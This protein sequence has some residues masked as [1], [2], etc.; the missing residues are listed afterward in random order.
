MTITLIATVLNEGDNIQR[1]MDTIQQQ[2]LQPD[3]IVIV[4]GG[5]RDQT[6]D[7]LRRYESVLPL[8]IFIEP[9]ANISRGRNIALH[10]ATGDII[11]ITDAGVRLDNDW[12]ENITQ[13]LRDNPS[14]TVSA[15]FFRADPHTVFEAALGAT[16]LPL[17]DE[18]NPATFLPSSRSVAVRREAALQVGGYPEWLDFCEDLIFDLRLQATQP[19][20]AF[21]PSAIAHFRPR[22]TL[23]AFYK[24]YYRYAR[25]D[26]KADLWRRRHAIRY[27]TYL[28]ALP[29]LIGLSIVIHPAFALLLLIGGALYTRTPYRRLPSVMALLPAASSIDWLYALSL[30]PVLRIVGDA[31]K[32]TG[33]PV[34]LWWRTQHRPPSWKL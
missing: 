21:V 31:A 32:M 15:G 28:I 2:T 33:Y 10:A 3:E 20:F 16:T 4:D 34:G 24:Q 18:I 8:R 26:G 6:V 19:P 30:I 27:V 25:G 23:S 13:P 1:L 14:S 22:P 7:I 11:A 9:G 5:S 12:L 17:V 29:F